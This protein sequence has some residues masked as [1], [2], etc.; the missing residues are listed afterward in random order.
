MSYR[1]YLLWMIGLGGFALL[2][3]AALNLLVDPFDIYRLVGSEEYSHFKEGIGMRMAKVEQLRARPWDVVLLGN[4]R[5]EVGLDPQSPAWGGARVY[6][7]GLPGAIFDEIDTE[8]R[9]AFGNSSLKRIVLCVDLGDF[10][11][12]RTLPDDDQLTLLNPS[13]NRM[14][15]RLASL[16][17]INAVA[18]SLGTLKNSSHHHPAMDWRQG[19]MDTPLVTHGWADWTLTGYYDFGGAEAASANLRISPSRL[20]GLEKLLEDACGRGIRVDLVELPTHVTFFERYRLA[21]KWD[22]YTQWVREMAEIADRC[23]RR[24]PECPVKFW[25]FFS[26]SRYTTE[27]I[28]GLGTTVTKMRWYWDGGHFKRELGDLV[29]DRLNDWPAPPGEDVSDFGV[30]LDSKNVGAFL[31]KLERDRRTYLDSHPVVRGMIER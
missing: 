26:Y 19:E 29:I 13:L 5:V 14:D 12:E 6:N 4:S 16:L 27:M 24:F 15:Y 17:S 28:P 3:V 31:E 11:A 30:V 21:G 23:S 18:K 9:I 1:R 8:A 10:D 25:D 2:G 20:A 22:V 7:A